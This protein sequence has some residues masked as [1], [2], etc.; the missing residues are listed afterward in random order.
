MIQSSRLAP[1]ARTL[2][3]LI[4]LLGDVIE[5][6]FQPETAAGPLEGLALL[7]LVIALS[8]SAYSLLLPVCAP[9][10]GIVTMQVTRTLP[11]WI[12]RSRP[13]LRLMFETA[14]TK[15]HGSSRT[16]LPPRRGGPC[17]HVAQRMG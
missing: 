8:L 15:S 12:V 17:T 16:A 4:L 10:P 11:V 3:S 1:P 5:V 2:P 14:V 13:R 6:V 7:A 9:N